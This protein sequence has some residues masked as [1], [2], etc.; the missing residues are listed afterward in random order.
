MDYTNLDIHARI[1]G[2]FLAMYSEPIQELDDGAQNEIAE[3]I[4]HRTACILMLDKMLE[5]AADEVT[6]EAVEYLHK[7]YT[8]WQ[9]LYF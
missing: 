8:R 5:A 1:L 2:L 9:Q 4:S 3:L 7:V 6:I